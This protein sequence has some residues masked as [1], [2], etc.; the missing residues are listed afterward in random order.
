VE[1]NDCSASLG[2]L[3]ASAWKSI[4]RITVKLSARSVG[5]FPDT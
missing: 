5:V 2:T 1:E 3:S 4:W